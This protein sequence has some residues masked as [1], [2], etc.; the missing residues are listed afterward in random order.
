MRTPIL[1]RP[2]ESGEPGIN[3]IWAPVFTG[4]TIAM[5]FFKR[6]SAT[7]PLNG[8]ARIHFGHGH[9]NRNI[10]RRAGNMKNPAEAGF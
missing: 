6:S 4:A 8:H 10:P 2:R 1:R 5:G 9:K 7:L 3:K